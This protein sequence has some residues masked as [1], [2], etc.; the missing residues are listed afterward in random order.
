MSL[1]VSQICVGRFHHFDLARQLLKRGMLTHFYTGYP[2]WKLHGEGL[3][4]DRVTSFPWL[5]T[6]C[7]ALGKWGVL[8]EPWQ[9]ISSWLVHETLDSYV[10]RH[11][12]SCDVLLALSGSG[13][14]SAREAAERGIR[15]VCDRGSSHIRYQDVILK[16]EFARWG[17]RFPGVDPRV[18][19]K[20]E[21][22]YEMADLV[23]V[24]SEFALL[25][26]VEMGVPQ[27]KLRKV[28]YGVDLRRF[29]KTTEPS[30]DVFEVLFVGQVSFRKGVPYLLKAFERLRHPHKRLRIIGGLQPE[31]ERFFK[32]H[33][34]DPTIAIL[35][36]LP[37]SALKEVMNHAHVMVLPSVEEGLALV[38]AQAMAC[39]CP[40]I[41][42]ANTGAADLFIDEVEG[43]IVPPRDPRAIADRLQLLADDPKRRELM[44]EAALR[45]ISSLGG[46]DDYGD[47]MV[48]V[49]TELVRG[50]GVSR[51]SGLEAAGV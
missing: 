13:L 22:E 40:V 30:R 25:S 1:K 24:P 51:Q 17:E 9:R 18:I 45:R 6:P 36:H 35:G 5:M 49:L 2:S 26:F 21:A 44:S 8:R 27:A 12:P 23:T 3:P 43:F 10:A 20:E 48:A 28:P 16:E 41:G 7:M 37:Q 39:G 46:W 19:A 42:T 50:Q 32:L 11:L 4:R 31:M 38:Q 29:A 15:F 47:R 33:P 14:R 34:P